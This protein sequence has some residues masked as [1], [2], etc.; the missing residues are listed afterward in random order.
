MSFQSN[1]HEID[2]FRHPGPNSNYST[3]QKIRGFFTGI[4]SFRYKERIKTL[5]S[6]KR[7]DIVQI[8]NLYPFISPS[9]LPVCKERNIPV[10]M[11]CPN[12]RLFCPN[13]LHLSQCA[14][15]KRCLYGKR[16]AVPGT[17]EIVKTI[18]SR[19][20]D[21]LSEIPRQGYPA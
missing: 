1:G 10:I 6:K 19:V 15:C 13:G 8:Q 12:Y 14:I 2:W 18:I 4:Y 17:S 3:G 5:L 16:M 7:Y 9:I 11:R 20:Q 21:T